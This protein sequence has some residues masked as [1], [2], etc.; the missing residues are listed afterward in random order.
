MSKTYFHDLLGRKWQVQLDAKNLDEI[1]T[2][3]GVN[4]SSLVNEPAWLVAAMC[5][6]KA[7]LVVLLSLSIGFQAVKR[8]IDPKD[9]GDSILKDGPTYLAA[10]FTLMHSLAELYPSSRLAR[11]LKA[12]EIPESFLKC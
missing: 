8:K 7:M 6:P 4:L 9:F 5:T 1:K 2:Q 12:E 10:R 11:I 3:F